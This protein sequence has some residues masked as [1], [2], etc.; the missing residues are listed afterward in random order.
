MLVNAEEKDPSVKNNI[1]NIICS[2]WSE[3]KDRVISDQYSDRL[4]R[5]GKYLFRGQGSDSW[6][7]STSFDRWYE[8]K[9]S[10]KN[11]SADRLLSE[12][13]LECEFEEMP[14]SLRRDNMAMLGLAQ[15][16][17]LP[18][19]LLDWSES[20]YVAAFFAFSGHVRQGIN[21]EKYVAVWVLD[22]ESKVWSE[23]HGCALVK[24][25]ALWNQRIRNQ[26]G[27]FTYLRTADDTL[28]NYVA[29]FE[30][31]EVVLKKYC[32]PVRDLLPAMSELDAM[33]LT[34]ARIYPG[35]EGN[36]RA[37]EVR[38]TLRRLGA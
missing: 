22:S 25:P 26:F 4:F 2:S 20:P 3:F 6:A 38:V 23:E 29:H 27:R 37:A 9:K 36:A 17:G 30:H 16:H 21:L 7:L 33:G 13:K 12:F 11:E 8:G 5:K 15:H 18:T 28:E 14:E 19:R 31:E 35:L 10:E 32:I 24:V 1:V 34:H